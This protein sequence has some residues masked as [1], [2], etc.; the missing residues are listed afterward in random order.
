MLLA[1]KKRDGAEIRLGPFTRF[2]LDG[3]EL[4]ELQGGPVLAR[5]EGRHWNVRGEAYL[6]LDYEGPLTITFEHSQIGRLSR[7]LGPFVHLSSVDGVTYVNHEV[8]CHFNH[9]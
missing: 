4:R 7:R 2:R 1:F 6:R 5:H 8:F 3:E 9:E